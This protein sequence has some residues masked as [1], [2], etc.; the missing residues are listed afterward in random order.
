MHVISLPV[1]PVMSMSVMSVLSAIV[2]YT[3]GVPRLQD[4]YY[5]PPTPRA[6]LCKRRLSYETSPG[7]RLFSGRA[8]I[9]QL[10]IRVG[11]RREFEADRG[12][13]C[14]HECRP[15]NGPQLRQILAAEY[16]CM[17]HHHHHHHHHHQQQE[18]ER[19]YFLVGAH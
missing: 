15:G 16:N 2:R 18:Q 11:A 17:V 1:M 14:V 4:G 10:Y 12:G 9:L 5:R 19:I 3:R 7:R 8:A 13:S 6:R